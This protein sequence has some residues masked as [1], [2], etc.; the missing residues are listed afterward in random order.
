[1]KPATAPA[2]GPEEL[3]E[4]HTRRIENLTRLLDSPGWVHL[5]EHLKKRQEEVTNQIISPNTPLDDVPV[6]RR[7]H[8]D[9]DYLIDL[10][11]SERAL[12]QGYLDRAK[13][14]ERGGAS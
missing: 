2:N 13:Q 9:Y 1:M 11:K 7:M 3:Q 5:A 4:Q 14:P 8:Q 6:L 10:P 12:S